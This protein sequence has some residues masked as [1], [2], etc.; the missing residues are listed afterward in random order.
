MCAIFTLNS[1]MI[2]TLWSLNSILS[3]QFVMNC[4]YEQ[5]EWNGRTTRMARTTVYQQNTFSMQYTGLPSFQDT[6]VS[7]EEFIEG[8]RQNTSVSLATIC[9]VHQHFTYYYRRDLR[10]WKH[11]QTKNHKNWKTKACDL[12][13]TADVKALYPSL[14]RDTVTK[15]LE[16]ALEKHSIF[17]N[18]APEN[19][20]K[21]TKLP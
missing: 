14:C 3:V 13:A 11:R 15:A 16:C 20:L 5:L 7:F 9:C 6:Q 17:N 10:K 2:V 12:H 19:L 21:W 8:W 1:G 18:K 4:C